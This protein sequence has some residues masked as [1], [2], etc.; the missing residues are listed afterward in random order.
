MSVK[1]KPLNLG[2]GFH[3]ILNCSG[4]QQMPVIRLGIEGR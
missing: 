1:V 2:T 3:K 4:L